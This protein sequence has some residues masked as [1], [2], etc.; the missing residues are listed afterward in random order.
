MITINPTIEEDIYWE[1]LFDHQFS[2]F[3]AAVPAD[4]AAFKEIMRAYSPKLFPVAFYV[5]KNRHISE[6]ILQEAFLKLW[7]KR[8]ELVAGNIGGWLYKVVINIAYKHLKKEARQKEVLNLLK[9]R[10]QAA[11]TEVEEQLVHK[12]GME[13]FSEACSRLPLKQQEVYRLSRE[14]GLKRGE[15]AQYLNIS[16]NTV[17]NHLASAVQFLKNHITSVC[18][19]LVFFVFNN[20]FFNEDSTNTLSKDLYRINRTLDKRIHTKPG[21]RVFDDN[22]ILFIRFY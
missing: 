2:S 1:K 20:L 16:S 7:E 10:K 3:K 8:M 14:E 21:S 12:Q 17:R 11:F 19:V 5:T 18:L 13:A 22:S 15:I 6:D 4:E 9:G